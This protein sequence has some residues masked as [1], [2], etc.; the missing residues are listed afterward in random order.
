LGEFEA[1][2]CLFLRQLLLCQLLHI[3]SRVYRSG[4]RCTVTHGASLFVYFWGG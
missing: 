4:V 1:Q 3:Q 2:S